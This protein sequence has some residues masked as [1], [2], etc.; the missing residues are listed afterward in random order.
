MGIWIYVVDI[1][2]F[3]S[4]CRV[5]VNKQLTWMIE[6]GV[7]LSRDY[8]QTISCKLLLASTIE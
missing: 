1:S 4:H 8:T 2:K 6:F 3:E 5:L 7:I